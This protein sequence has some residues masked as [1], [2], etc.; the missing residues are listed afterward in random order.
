MNWSKIRFHAL[1][2]SLIASAAIY[3]YFVWGKRASVLVGIWLGFQVGLYMG[4]VE[5]IRRCMKEDRADER[6]QSANAAATGQLH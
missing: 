2:L 6:R 1:S 3:L 4:L 5:N